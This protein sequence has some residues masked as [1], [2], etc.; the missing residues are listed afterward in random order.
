MVFHRHLD[1][2]GHPSPSAAAVSAAG[3]LGGT[4]GSA[5]AS[6][7]TRLLERGR[8]P[9]S[10]PACDPSF[11]ELSR[12]RPVSALTETE[13]DSYPASP[14]LEDPEGNIKITIP[15]NRPLLGIVIEGG[16]NTS[17]PLPRIVNIQPY[18]SAFSAGG[19]MVG[20]VIRSVDG[21][22]LV[23]VNHQ[24]AAQ[25]IAEAYANKNKPDIEFVVRELKRSGFNVK[26]C[27][28]DI[29]PD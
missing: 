10:D 17:Q 20:Q 4:G 29:T 6:G 22:K 15:K 19:L 8:L 16:A 28:P 2:G 27:A 13:M 24:R 7:L 21:R 1:D 14:I 12:L 5:G 23:G 25:V 3:A 11:S 18:G 26:H 9:T